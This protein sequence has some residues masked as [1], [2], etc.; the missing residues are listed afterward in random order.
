M[1]LY[2]QSINEHGMDIFQLKNPTVIF[3]KSQMAG[4][5]MPVTCR[6][7]KILT[8]MRLIYLSL[9]PPSEFKI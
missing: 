4:I 9:L 1:D 5:N 2:M 7:I 8:G 3:L 6:Q